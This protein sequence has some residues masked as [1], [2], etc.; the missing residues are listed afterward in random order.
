ML[1]IHIYRLSIDTRHT[2]LDVFAKISISRVAKKSPNFLDIVSVILD[3]LS[4]SRLPPEIP[5][6]IVGSL[7]VASDKKYS[8]H[9]ALKGKA[10]TTIGQCK[11]WPLIQH[12]VYIPTPCT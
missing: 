3:D 4:D 7:G 8:T 5:L 9:L 6:S 12:Q 1:Q 2:A 11:V 10:V